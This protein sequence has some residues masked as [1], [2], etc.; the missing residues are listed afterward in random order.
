MTHSAGVVEPT[1]LT[2]YLASRGWQRDGTYRGAN[3]WRL[4]SVGKLLVPERLDYDDD[5][6]LVADA[7]RRLAEFE[8]RPAREVVRDIAEPTVDGQYYRLHP[9]AAPG[10]IPLPSGLKAVA[11]IHDLLGAAA[12]SAY[13]GPRLH[14]EGR[15]SAAVENFLHGVLLGSAVPGSYVLTARIPLRQ[16]RQPQSQLTLYESTAET[17]DQREPGSRQVL[18]HLRGAVRAAHV[19]AQGVVQG[20]RMDGFY[21]A[22]GEGVSANLCRSLADLGGARKRERFDIG[23]TWARASP[24]PERGEPVSFTA[25]MASVLASAGQ[26]LEQLAK[27]G[28]ARVTGQVETLYLRPGEQPRIKIAGDLQYQTG[29]LLPRRSLWV[30]VTMEEYGQAY[31][32]QRQG[33]TLDIEG[34]L[35]T[36]QRRLELRPSRFEVLNE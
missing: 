15:R 24:V 5:G 6:E 23:F 21:D 27:S 4:E 19:A 29:T 22:V 34:Q 25:R 7:V 20:E 1:D 16:T 28:G 9:D 17:N 3:V 31:E 10:L 12:R 32:A 2:G 35:H 36:F 8:E 18:L 13:E 26:E 11:G 30:A 33:L 14:F